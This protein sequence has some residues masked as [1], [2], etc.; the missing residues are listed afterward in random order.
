M[1]KPERMSKVSVTGTK[2]VMP[3]VIEAVHDLDLVHISEYQGE[4]SGFSP[5]DPIEGAEDASERLVTVRSLQSI[6]EVTPE[7]AGDARILEPESM[8]EE[9]AAVQTEVNDLDDRRSELREERRTV[10]GRLDDVEPFVDLGIDFDLLRGYDTLD[11]AV[12]YADPAAVERALE[13]AAGLRTHEVFSG[14]ETVAAVAVPAEDAEDPLED[15]LVGTDFG[16]IDVPD[17]EGDP[18]SHARELESERERLTA[19]IEAVEDEL[20]ALG[21]EHAAFL[22]AAEETLTIEVQKTEAPL[23]FATTSRAFV[24][25]GWVPTDR[26]DELE[27]ALRTSVGDSAA[28]EELQRAEYDDSGH[29]HTVESVDDHG[30]EAESDE[31]DRRETAADGGTAVGAAEPP[32]MQDNTEPAKP[33]ELLT[34]M[35]GFPSY[36]ELDPTFAIMLT[37]PLFF[38]FM[39]GDLGYGLIY[40]TAGYAMATRFDNDAVRSLGGIGLWAGAF[41]ML[42]GV[43]YGEVFGLHVLGDVVWGGHPPMHKGLQPAFSASGQTWLVVSLL[44]GLA[45]MTIGYLFGAVNDLKHGV[46]D[47]VTEDLSWLV[48]MGGL[49]LW[50]LSR[51]G[52]GSK[53]D[54]LFEVLGTGEG[55]V[56]ELG[57]TGLPVAVGLGGLGLFALGLA[58][59]SYGE[60]THMGAPGLL[61]GPLE[62]VNVLVNVLSYLRM[63]AVLLAKAGMAFVVNLLFFG[64]YVVETDSGA[65]WHFGTS[66][67]PEHML[68]EGT[69]H[70]HEVTEV[71][72]GGLL[73]GGIGMALMGVFVLVVGHIAVLLLGVTSAGLQGIRLEYVEFFDKFYEGDGYPFEPFGYE[74]RFTTED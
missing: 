70:G 13:D 55:A 28:I 42:F 16:R 3:D 31:G 29:A 5:G 51:H 54:L 24:A 38:G 64:A 21:E 74:R 19:E 57:F 10:E 58:V 2:A 26:Y 46:S 68:A 65:E 49:W 33:F 17:I 9:L 73:H 43:L 27:A 62:S 44:V 1:L 66:H 35:V 45:H 47:V 61:V 50:I 69:Y 37:F 4:W 8:A 36:D 6:L 60:F 39:I 18:E 14:E 71:M 63:A 25:E 7:D 72:F 15:A 30:A 23:S 48:M 12:G 11:V 52:E 41:T 59:M 53:P 40:T 22:L 56:Y 32:T 34:R 67:S 20:D